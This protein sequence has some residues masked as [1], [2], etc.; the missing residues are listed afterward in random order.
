MYIFYSLQN[1]DSLHLTFQKDM[2]PVFNFQII[3]CIYST[4]VLPNLIL[5]WKVDK[6]CNIVK[7]WSKCAENILCSWNVGAPLN[8]M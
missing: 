5:K 7:L 8:K 4:H 1:S 3:L 6:N 2:L